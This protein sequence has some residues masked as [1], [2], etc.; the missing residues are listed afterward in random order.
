[1]ASVGNISLGE[2]DAEVC[3][4]ASKLTNSTRYTAAI[5]LGPIAWR[6]YCTWRV[7]KANSAHHAAAMLK[8]PFL[9]FPSPLHLPSNI[10]VSIAFMTLFYVHLSYIFHPLKVLSRSDLFLLT[11]TSVSAPIVQIR[12]RIASMSFEELGWRREWG[13]EGL[14]TLLRRLGSFEGRKL[15]LMIGTSPFL[16]CLYCTVPKDYLL[17]S[18]SDSLWHISSNLLLFGVL[19]ARFDS[20][21]AF[22]EGI[23]SLIKLSTG[24]DLRRYSTSSTPVAGSNV[25]LVRADGYSYRVPVLYLLGLFAITQAAVLQDVIDISFGEGRW[26]HASSKL[27][28]TTKVQ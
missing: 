11:G 21:E 23:Y 27:G 12:S 28:V 19:T 26:D 7:Q 4:S 8:R 24:R 9:S 14:E 3:P 22:D 25:V 17:F 5:I 15:H 1:M 20:L 2:Y 18:I 13:D 6:R 10:L 16:S